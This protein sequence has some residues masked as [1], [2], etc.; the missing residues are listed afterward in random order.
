MNDQH[1][2]NDPEE[3][4]NEEPQPVHA[5][6]QHRAVTARLR[7]DVRGGVFSNAAIVLSGNFE[8]VI[9]FV[10]RLGKPD[11]VT[12][13]VILP[14]PVADQFV[15]ALKDSI[16]N[17]EKQFGEIPALPQASTKSAAEDSDQSGQN[18][19]LPIQHDIGGFVGTTAPDGTLSGEIPGQ[20]GKKQNAPAIDEIYDDLKLEDALL[21]GVYANAVLLRHS[22][23]EFCFD[24]VTNIYPRSCVNA[25]VFMAAPQVKPL[26]S[27]LSHSLEQ[28]RNRN[29]PPPENES[30][31]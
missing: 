22:A 12:A 13:R 23:T 26:W 9:D 3:H 5:E 21:G 6:F 14:V 7:E 19:N 20:A 18:P 17:Y 8:F 11:L 31:N 28:Y 29:Q 15:Q 4:S 25:R 30:R 10:L 27:T 2:E 24:F 1:P 16:K